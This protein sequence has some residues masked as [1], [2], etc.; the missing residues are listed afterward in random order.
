MAAQRRREGRF[1]MQAGV[2][3]M[4]SGG[5][6]HGDVVVTLSGELCLATIAG[7]EEKLSAVE[8]SGVNTLALDL[9]R[10]TVIDSIGMRLILRAHRRAVLGGYR[11]VLV[12]GPDAIQRPFEIC[13]LADR[14]P[15]VDELGSLEPAPTRARTGGSAARQVGVSRRAGAGALAS[16]VLGLRSQRRRGSAGR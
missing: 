11:L 8:R 10:L 15:F 13:G 9:S 2:H 5:A 4:R 7:V 3:A 16:A 12:R 6:G 1:T 14:L